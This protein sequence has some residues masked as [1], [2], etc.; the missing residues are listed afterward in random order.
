MT[1]SSTPKEFSVIHVTPEIWA[2]P[3][4]KLI[5]LDL[6]RFATRLECF[7]TLWGLA[8]IDHEVIQLSERPLGAPESHFCL[9]R[10][11]T[12]RG[13]EFYVFERRFSVTKQ[14]RFGSE[15]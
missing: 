9:K 12:N 3:T 13:V 7:S 14:K 11:Y 1:K 15:I 6:C 4:F 5:I 10:S 8:N 2:P